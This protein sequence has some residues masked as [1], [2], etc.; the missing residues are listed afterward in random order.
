[1]WQIGE[2]FQQ[3][4]V[5]DLQI[6]QRRIEL[7]WLQNSQIDFQIV[8]V[9]LGLVTDMALQ[10]WQMLWI[11]SKIEKMWYGWIDCYRLAVAVWIVRL[12]IDAHSSCIENT[13]NNLITITVQSISECLGLKVHSLRTLWLDLIFIASTKSLKWAKNSFD[14]QKH[15]HTIYVHIKWNWRGLSNTLTSLLPSGICNMQQLHGG[16]HE[17]ENDEFFQATL[18]HLYAAILQLFN[19]KIIKNIFILYLICFGHF[20][21]LFI[22]KI[23]ISR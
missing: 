11:V 16:W 15:T 17:S 7:V 14:L 18:S 6:Q 2:C 20:F 22:F 10:S 12:W 1:M 4:Q 5:R 21:Y 9:I 3:N 8:G 19:I 23:Q 13:T